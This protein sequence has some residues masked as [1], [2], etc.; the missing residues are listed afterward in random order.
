MRTFAFLSGLV[1]LSALLLAVTSAPVAEANA[2]SAPDTAPA[3]A[4]LLPALESDRRILH[5]DDD[6]DDE[7]SCL[8]KYKK[9]YAQCEKNEKKCE[10]K[11]ED[12]DDEKVCEK[13]SK[14]CEAKAY[15]SYKSCKYGKWGCKDW[16]KY[17][18]RKCYSKKKSNCEEKYEDCKEDC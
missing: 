10:D 5:D 15:R 18:K 3:V 11:A 6:D 13:K 4:E 7:P 17:Y 2:V 12:E 9:R 16:C 1:L 14:T 8:D